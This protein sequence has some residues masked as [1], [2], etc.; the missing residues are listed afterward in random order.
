MFCRG[1]I[2]KDESLI[3]GRE[4]LEKVIVFL[5][6][7][8][9]GIRVAVAGRG[10]PLLLLQGSSL[11]SVL[12]EPSLRGVSQREGTDD[13]L[14]IDDVAD[15]GDAVPHS[16]RRGQHPDVVSVLWPRHINVQVPVGEDILCQ[17]QPHSLQRL[18]LYQ[19]QFLLSF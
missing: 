10:R 4:K 19:T 1:R 13:E 11:V 16:L 7:M 15:V 8:D 2:G 12:K 14:L 18:A 17:V 3:D 9:G 5:V 6:G